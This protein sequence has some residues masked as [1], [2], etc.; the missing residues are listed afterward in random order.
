MDHL[1]GSKSFI[2]NGDARPHLLATDLGEA[3]KE[4][5]EIFHIQFCAIITYVCAP[6]C[7]GDESDREWK[8]VVNDE[9]NLF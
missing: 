1:V 4:V 8:T 5:E 6:E 2:G 7:A 9:Q 3:G